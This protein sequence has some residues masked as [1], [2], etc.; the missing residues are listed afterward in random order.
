[1]TFE[2]RVLQK[3]DEIQSQQTLHGIAIAVLQERTKAPPA[4]SKVVTI[5]GGAAAGAV[6]ALLSFIAAHW[7]KP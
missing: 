2:E 4:P 3:L 5:S 7:G 1:M 6:G